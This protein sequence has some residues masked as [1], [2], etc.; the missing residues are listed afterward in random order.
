[1][2]K[3]VSQRKWVFGAV[4]AAAM[5]STASAAYAADLGGSIKDEAVYAE[6]I[7]HAH[8]RGFYIGANL[9]GAWSNNGDATY[10]QNGVGVFSTDLNTSSVI[11]GGQIG[12]N[13]QSG[14]LVVGIEADI[15]AQNLDSS[16]QFGVVDTVSHSSK[17]RWLG[18][19]R[20]RIGYAAG[21]ALIYVTGGLAYANVEHAYE[22]NRTTVPGAVRTFSDSSTRTGWT[23]GAGVEWA[24]MRNWSLGAEYLHVD[25]GSTTL[26]AN[27]STVA[28]VAFPAS[29]ARFEDR[30]DIVRAKLNYKF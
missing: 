1:M 26:S 2:S 18:T 9:G 14:Q 22:E 29:S 25:L 15:A 11:G 20:P 13:W 8:W 19:V 16:A 4:V 12:Y 17:S 24:F 27:A 5:A 30:E 23:L 7:R 28:G 10:A 21:N 3:Y 6:P